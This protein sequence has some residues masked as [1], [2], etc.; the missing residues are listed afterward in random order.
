MVPTLPLPGEVSPD[1]TAG[2]RFVSAPRTSWG[3]RRVREPT[4]NLLSLHPEWAFA[5]VPRRECV[6]TFYATQAYARA[7]I[8]G[9][10]VM[11]PL[12]VSLVV[13]PQ[14]RVMKVSP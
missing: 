13:G 4:S 5:S 14:Q 9:D 2:E 10:R 7:V 8:P 12:V 3:S 11:L 1:A 6:F